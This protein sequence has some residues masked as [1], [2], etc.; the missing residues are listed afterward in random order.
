ML[1]RPRASVD[2]FF[3]QTLV[4]ALYDLTSTTSTESLRQLHRLLFS[5][6]LRT[7]YNVTPVNSPGRHEPKS[8]S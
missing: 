4:L 5:L 1:S 3:S 2:K 8:A 7:L 6:P